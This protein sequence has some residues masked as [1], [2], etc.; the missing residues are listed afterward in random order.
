MNSPQMFSPQ[1]VS[2]DTH[3]LVSYYP[4]PGAG[5]LPVNSFLIRGE[6]PVSGRHWRCGA[7]R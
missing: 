3:A 7:S 2:S 6:Q 1:R 4:L 5:I